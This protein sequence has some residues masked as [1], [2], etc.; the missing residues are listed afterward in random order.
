MG[1]APA[2]FRFEDDTDVFTPLG[3]VEQ[4]VLNNR[5]SHD[6]IFTVARLKAGISVAQ[7]QA[8]MSSIQNGLDQIYPSDN[9][10]LGVY[11]EP[12]KQAIVGSVGETLALLFGAVCL[13]LMIS[14]ANVSNLLLARYVSHNR[15][16]AIRMA[17]G[18]SRNRVA[19]QVLAEN[20]VL[21]LTGAG[22]GIVIAFVTLRFVLPALGGILPRTQDVTVNLS[23]LLYTLVVSLF[24]G[25]VSGLVPALKISNAG[26]QTSLKDGGHGG[27]PLVRRAQSTFIFVQVGSTLVLLVVAGLLFR[28]ILQL[29]RVN[30]G[31]DTQNIV[32]LKVGVSPSPAQTPASIRVAYQQLIERIRNI[33]GVQAAEFTTAVPLTGQGGYL[34]FWLDSRKPDSLQGAPRLQ[35]FL[36]GPDYLRATGIPLLRGRFLSS[37]DT[38]KTPCVTVI[39]SDFAHK[40]FPDRRPLG[41][42]ITAGFGSA[43]FGPCT[44]VGVVGHVKSTSLN[45][46]ALAHQIQAYYSLHQDPDQWVALNYADA[47]LILRT[48]LEAAAILPAIKATVYLSDADQPIYDVMTMRQIAS[49][50][51]SEQRFPMM[52]LGLFAA[53]SLLLASIGLYGV[54]AYAVTRRTK[55]I[56]IRMALGAHKTTVVLMFVW[57]SLRLVLVGIAIGAAGALV[58]VRS[59]SILSHVLYGVRPT[60]PMTFASCALLLISAAVLASYIPA[61]R[62]VK[63]DPVD[64][65][66]TE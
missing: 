28:T 49:A 8:E 61:R 3:Q 54:I 10:E 6:G 2:N 39:D 64:A 58:A 1:I 30:P 45:D 5:G 7:S 9:R 62:A 53:L 66:R 16:F 32:T 23:V 37:S 57:Q 25:I 15:E 21:S 31:F 59:L 18:A 44:I 24:V 12:L 47:T 55:E 27:T 65:L 38:T 56:G 52:L 63:V 46:A 29:W 51:M 40:F 33:P 60:D 11:V 48:P 26:P 13:V 22:L 36:T 43:A 34:P 17:L 19:Q 35:P 41:H 14:C 20:I 42:T 50:S 4:L